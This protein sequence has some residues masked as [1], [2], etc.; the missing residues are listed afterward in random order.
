VIVIS[1][2]KKQVLYEQKADEL[3]IPASLNKLVTAFATLKRLKPTG[4]FKTTIYSTGPVIDGKLGG[5]L[6]IKGGGDPGL[7]SER[8]W[9][10]VNDFIR[11]NIKT[12]TGDLVADSSYFDTERQPATRPRYLTD[13]AYNAPI[14]AL[15]F[16]FNTTTIYVNPANTIN[17]KPKVYIDPENPYIEIVNQSKTS[18][19]GARNRLSVSRIKHVKGDIGDTILLRGSI[20]MGFREMRFYRNIVNPT[21]Y[22]ANMFRVFLERRGIKVKGKTVGGIVPPNAK[23]LLEFESLPLWQVVWGMNKFSNNF[24]ADQLV[25]KLGAETWGPPGTMKKGL[26]TIYDVLEDIGISRSSYKV[27]D[28]SGLTRN[29]PYREWG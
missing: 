9:M 6:Y 8:M 26:T 3:F 4:T 20:P 22:T 12:I 11:R 16:N 19:R 28:G 27:I 10:M 17:A 13:Q 7:V 29:W 15:S 21:L 18:R 14:G 5:D 1:L 23:K 2:D 25:K 24:V